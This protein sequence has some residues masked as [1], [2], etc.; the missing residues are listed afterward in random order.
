MLPCVYWPK[1][2]VGLAETRKMGSRDCRTPPAFRELDQIPQFC[3]NCRFIDSCRGGCPSRRLLRGG[4]DRPDEFCP[5][6]AGKPLPTFASRAGSLRQFSKAGSACTT[7]FGVEER[8]ERK[9]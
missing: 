3:A 6:V 7:V 5:F 2:N 4:L 1:R 8:E 9:S